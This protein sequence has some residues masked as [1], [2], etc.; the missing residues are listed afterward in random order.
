MFVSGYIGSSSFLLQVKQVIQDLK[1]VNPNLIYG[2]YVL[3]ITVFVFKLHQFSRIQPFI[4]V[5]MDVAATACIT[6]FGMKWWIKEV[7][8]I[9][10]E[11]DKPVGD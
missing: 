4:D 8:H 6:F 3:F 2:L 9:R 1:R 10:K 11:Q 7:I 5:F